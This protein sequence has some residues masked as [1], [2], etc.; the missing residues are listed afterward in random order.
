M[1][2][3]LLGAVGLLLLI[4]CAN[5]ANLLLARAATR[6]REIA[7]RGAL[8]AGRRRIVRQLLT[9]SLVLACAGG[10]LG[11]VLAAWG[12]RL[13]RSVVPDMFPMLQHMRV[14]MPRAGIHLRHLDSYRLALR[15]GSRMEIIA[16]R[17]EHDP[18]GSRRTF[19]ERRRIA[20]YPQLPA[21]IGSGAG[22]VAFG[23][24]RL[25][26]RS[27]VRVTAVDPGVRT[28]NILTMNVSLPEAKYD[29]PLQA[30]ELL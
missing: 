15:T 9:E 26:L 16:H 29:T 27:F 1:L 8:G 21:G 25:L 28:A 20:A 11:L 3:I 17:P 2:L 5:L 14:D 6:E 10:A 19:G 24:R 30:R 18:Q 4:A 22:G 7:I 23:Q 12:V 13:M